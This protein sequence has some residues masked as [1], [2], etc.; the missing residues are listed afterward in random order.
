MTDRHV[1]A[2]LEGAP[3]GSLSEAELATV[4]AHAGVCAEC[5]RAFD[6]ARVSSLLLRE[7]AAAAAEPSPF[8]QTRVLAAL[9]ERQAAGGAWSFARLW[10]SAGALV[11]SMAASVALLAGLIFVAPDA[12]PLPEGSEVASG[13]NPYS[14]EDVLLS[15]EGF[16]G[17][18][19]ND[20]QVFTT[21][22]GSEEEESK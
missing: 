8:F 20:S 7:R 15:E 10:K 4:R 9:R 13:T 22:Y 12:Q 14:A 18:E 3:F 5:R 11:V 19:L 2:I 16:A 17:E 6:A 21:I 1:I